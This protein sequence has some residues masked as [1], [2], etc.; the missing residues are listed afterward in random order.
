ME[1][2]KF[3]NPFNLSDME[4]SMKEY[5]ECG[6]QV[7]RILNSFDFDADAYKECDRLLHELEPLGYTFDYGLDGEPYN[8]YKINRTNEL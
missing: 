1:D 8:L 4:N 2:N 5:N 7:R 6:Y 3:I